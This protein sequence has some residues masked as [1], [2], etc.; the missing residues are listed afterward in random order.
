MK[1]LFEST[2]FLA[3][4]TGLI[5]IGWLP[6]KAQS[7]YI[8]FQDA[9]GV[10]PSQDQIESLENAACRLIDSFPAIYQDSFRVF[11]FGFYL[12]N[13]F[14][15]GGY[16]EAFQLAIDD[17]QSQSPY[18]LLFGKQTDQSGVYTRFWVDLR[19]PD[20]G[21]FSCINEMSAYLRQDVENKLELT[22][23]NVHLENN[24]SPDQFHLAELAAMNSLTTFIWNTVACCDPVNNNR[25]FSSCSACVFTPRELLQ[26]QKSK[27][28]LFD[29]AFV[30][31]DP[32]YIEDSIA[33]FNLKSLRNQS[34]PLDITIEF[35]DGIAVDLDSFANQVIEDQKAFLNNQFGLIPSVAIHTFK[36]PRDCGTFEE[37]WN[38]YL[39]DGAELKFF[40]SFV[41]T[42]NEFGVLGFHTTSNYNWSSEGDFR[43]A[44]NEQLMKDE[45][46]GMKEVMTTYKKSC[47][48]LLNASASYAGASYYIGQDKYPFQNEQQMRQAIDLYED[49]FHGLNEAWYDFHIYWLKEFEATY[50][51]YNDW[52]E[53]WMGCRIRAK[54]RTTSNLC[55]ETIHTILDIC[56]LE[57]TVLGPIC[58]GTNAVLYLISGDLSNAT[59]SAAALVPIAG[60]G[61][62][63][64]KY[65]GRLWKTLDGGL[66]GSLS[67]AAKASGA[68]HWVGGSGKLRNLIVKHN[69]KYLFNGVELVYDA[70]KHE[71]HHLIPW[72]H[73]KQLTQHPI[74]K[75]LAI[76]G[77]HASD[78]FI[79]GFTIPKRLPNGTLFHAT[80]YEYNKWVENALNLL[81]DFPAEQLYSKMEKLSDLLKLKIEDACQKGKKLNDYFKETKIFE[82]DDLSI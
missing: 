79:N 74:M 65:G 31:N 9:S 35:G 4:L 45:L 60:Y 39:S 50:L 38:D 1:K 43:D 23:N 10:S 36:Y 17:A 73:C 11:D 80:H 46:E 14:T 53:C 30:L 13:E 12:H 6:I 42:D 72:E 62:N 40:I 75:K 68:V 41:N 70:T 59:L 57:P 37:K 82:L 44:E 67:F 33:A 19:L 32:E 24:N 55:G 52:S 78:P 76:K 2:W 21:E 47:E 7:C 51:E 18:Y 27:R 8:R 34:A 16:P 69:I 77:W 22:A 48:E 26:I 81:D 25:S 63:G 49:A 58:D 64:I 54:W 5:S 61:A 66:G 56:G 29:F 15:D 28:L 3:L 20:E 71:I